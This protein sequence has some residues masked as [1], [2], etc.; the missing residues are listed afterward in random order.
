MKIAFVL[1]GGVDRS[2]DKRV[3]PALLWLIERLTAAG[4]ELHVFALN[5]EPRPARWPLLGATIHN[6]GARPRQLRAFAD[7]VAEHRRGP[8]DVVHGFWAT[9]PGVVS[10][11]FARLAGVPAVLTV[12]GS[13]VT[14]LPEIGYGGQLT[15]IW[16]R[17]TRFALAGADRV[18]AESNWV[19]DRTARFGVAVTHLPYG[20]ALDRWPPLAP[21]RRDTG[22]PLRLL[23][24]ASLN[25]VKDQETLLLALR[26]LKMRGIAFTLDSVGVDTLNGAV[27][28]RCTELG[29]ADSVA[30]HGLLT[31]GEHRRWFEQADLL[32][33]SSRHEGGPLVVQEA[34][35]AGVPTVGT[36]VGHIADWAPDAALAVPVGDWAA[37][38]DAVAGLA[39]DEEKRLRLAHAAQARALEVDAEITAA[40]LRE[41]Y[42]DLASA[43]RRNRRSSGCRPAA[44]LRP[45]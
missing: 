10:A 3:I 5:Q 7:L 25:L 18:I 14:A 12:P 22:R 16:R 38:A 17:A 31:H 4:D 24:A 35:V 2:G 30:F 41:I 36:A 43:P 40:R 9:G 32:V 44:G 6:A 1:P 39:A 42:R 29:L 28:R 13:E 27:Q 23:H 19:A 37:L 34:G 33:M 11:A 20:I 15:W 8:F 26:A 21:R 45:D